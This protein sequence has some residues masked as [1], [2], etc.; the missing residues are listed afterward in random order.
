MN[1]ENVLVYFSRI[2]RIGPVGNYFIEN[3]LSTM[4]RISFSFLTLRFYR[5][6][7]YIDRLEKCLHDDLYFANDGEGEKKI[8]IPRRSRYFYRVKGGK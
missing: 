1:R 7:R 4:K 6:Y 2:E 5:Y 3:T 8:S